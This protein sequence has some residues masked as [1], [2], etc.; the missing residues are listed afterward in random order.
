[1]NMVDTSDGQE[2]GTLRLISYCPKHCTPHPETAGGLTTSL[3]NVS[4]IEKLL[5]SVSGGVW[6][7]YNVSY[8]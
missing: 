3:C 7:R 5:R 8:V 1:M 2:E 4:L 6:S